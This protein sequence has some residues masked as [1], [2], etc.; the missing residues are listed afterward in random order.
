MDPKKVAI[1]VVDKSKMK[2]LLEN[3]A[4]PFGKD[5]A[6]GIK[7][8]GDPMKLVQ[9][10][11]IVLDTR[12]VDKA[13]VTS[14]V[15]LSKATFNN[16]YVVLDLVKDYDKLRQDFLS[17]LRNKLE[18]I[19]ETS[20]LIFS[21]HIRTSSKIRRG[22]RTFKRTINEIDENMD[23]K[24]STLGVY[25]PIQY[26]N[27]QN[28][29]PNEYIPKY[30]YSAPEKLLIKSTYIGEDLHSYPARQGN[31]IAHSLVSDTYI[32]NPSQVFKKFN[33]YTKN[34]IINEDL[35]NG[36]VDINIPNVSFQNTVEYNKNVL[37]PE[38]KNLLFKIESGKKIIIHADK[39]NKEFLFFTILENI[40]KNYLSKNLKITIPS[41]ERL[42]IKYYQVF[43]V[44]N[45]NIEVWNKNLSNDIVIVDGNILKLFESHTSSE[46]IDIEKFQ[47]N[48]AI[49]G[50]PVS[51][52]AVTDTRVEDSSDWD[53]LP[54]QTVAYEE[55]VSE[56]KPVD[57]MFE[58]S[59]T[60]AAFAE[61]FNKAKKKVESKTPFTSF[62]SSNDFRKRNPSKTL[63][64]L[65]QAGLVERECI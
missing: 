46:N 20:T 24:L 40:D 5:L 43:I 25:T 47:V 14:T 39:T 19:N 2:E 1:M 26:K 22:F 57:D 12:K 60:K 53:S 27:F 23:G 49:F 4:A 62:G 36:I 51:Q 29:N 54:T 44:E 15:N 65:L 7:V 28:M 45:T 8:V 11:L 34:R 56:E 33:W 18:N 35:A 63:D 61:R 64:E 52:V 21:Q 32:K 55:V 17:K 42:D 41:D 58:E 13:L 50:F 6:S 16:K 59:D 30:I 37:S 3:E 48:P 10:V 38:F 9:P 31:Y